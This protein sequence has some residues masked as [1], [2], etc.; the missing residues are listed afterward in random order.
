M[1]SVSLADRQNV[2]DKIGIEWDERKLRRL[3]AEEMKNLYFKDS[4][5]HACKGY[6]RG[7]ARKSSQPVQPIAV[8]A[9]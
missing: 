6:T 1:F 4:A 7:T 3:I 5:R 8:C 2:T 9:L